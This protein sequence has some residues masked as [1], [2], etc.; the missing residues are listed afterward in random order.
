MWNRLCIQE[1]PNDQNGSESED[2]YCVMVVQLI[3]WTKYVVGVQA[4]A[5]DQVSI[6]ATPVLAI[7]RSDC[8]YYWLLLKFCHSSSI[9]DIHSYLLYVC[10][11]SHIKFNPV[12]NRDIMRY[13]LT[14]ICIYGL[15]STFVFTI[16]S[17]KFSSLE[18]LCILIPGNTVVTFKIWIN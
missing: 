17:V 5:D 10:I 13:I 2:H 8:E 3:S 1:S 4:W 6:A 11:Y 14:L 9:Q 12:Y 15:W 7:T 18:K 16:I